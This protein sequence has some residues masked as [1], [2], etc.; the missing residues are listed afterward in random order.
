MHAPQ[1]RSDAS[2]NSETVYSFQTILPLLKKVVRIDLLLANRSGT[3]TYQVLLVL[4]DFP[5]SQQFLAAIRSRESTNL[6][7]FEPSLREHV[8]GS[9]RELDNL[10]PHDNHHSSRIMRTHHTHFGIP[11]GIAPGWWDDRKR[12]HKPVLP[13][14]YLPSLG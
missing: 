6:K 1:N 9:W 14:T 2:H 4:Q 10:T 12:N 7:Q 5:A 13:V 3:W 11:L 8:I